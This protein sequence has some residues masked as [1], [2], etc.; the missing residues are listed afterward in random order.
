MSSVVPQGQ[1]LHFS[2][3]VI[4]H[5]STV[6]ADC[7][8]T[9]DPGNK[10]R[11][12]VVPELAKLDPTLP[13]A[14][15]EIGE[16]RFLVLCEKSGLRFG[17]LAHS[18]TSE[19]NG[20]EFLTNLQS[21]WVRMNGAGAVAPN[22]EFGQTELAT[23]LRSYNSAQYDKIARIRDSAQE[24]QREMSQN[25]QRALERGEAIDDMSSKADTLR[26]SAQTFHRKATDLKNQMCWEKWRWRLLAGGV[27]LVVILA[28]VWFACGLKFDKC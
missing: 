26:D 27:V 9:D 6:L 15:G 22:P 21:R 20:F 7:S 4:A 25:I 13:R 18:T 12:I 19:A 2:Y 10:N 14:V 1:V 17:C 16:S 8:A 11:G 3:A 5:N 24:A 23:Q 28:I